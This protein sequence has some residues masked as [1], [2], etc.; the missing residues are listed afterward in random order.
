MRAN[1]GVI[2][3]LE[4]Y[5]RP[6]LGQKVTKSISFV[7]FGTGLNGFPGIVHGGALLTLLDEAMLSILSTNTVLETGLGFMKVGEEYWRQ[8]LLEGK[9]PQETLKGRLATARMD[10]KLLAPVLCPGVV[11]IE[12]EVVEDKGHKMRMRA[13]MK[14]KEGK[15]LL[16]ADG[17]WVRIG[18]SAKL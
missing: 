9:S 11:G 1:N 3:W 12:T 2:Q 4:L 15:P 6:A 8:Q 17:L 10:V 13:T 5:E 14:D 16:Q 18:G 7:K